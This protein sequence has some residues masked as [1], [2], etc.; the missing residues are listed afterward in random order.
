MVRLRAG[1]R[2][3]TRARLLDAGLEVFVE[4]GYAATTVEDIASRAG[5]TR[6]T[7]YAYFPSQAELVR[8]L[9][10]ER[11]NDVLERRQSAGNGSTAPRLVDAIADG[12]P[13]RIEAWLRAVSDLWPQV[14]PILRVA[15]DASVVEPELRG[16]VARWMEEATGDIRAGLD[17][18]GRFEPHQRHFRGVLAMAQLDYVAQHWETSDWGLSREQMLHELS[19]SWSRLLARTSE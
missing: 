7:F 5:T 16:L 10:E 6:V 14:R 18:A 13:D 9:V 15:R 2:A 8:V 1:Q 11:L 19:A 3:T 12:G 4:K 17:R